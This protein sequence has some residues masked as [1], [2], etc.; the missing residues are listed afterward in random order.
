MFSAAPWGRT[1]TT[2]PLTRLA[3]FSHDA[4]EFSQTSGG[5]KAMVADA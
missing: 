1:K 2:Y 3:A 5:Y 4:G